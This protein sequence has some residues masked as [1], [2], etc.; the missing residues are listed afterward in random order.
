MAIT[1]TTAYLSELKKNVNTPNVIVEVSLDSGTLK[2]GFH[3]GGFSDVR[4]LLKSIG[5]LQNRLDTE[6][7]YSTRGQL[8]LVIT[9]RDNFKNFIK[10]NYLKNRRIVRKDGFLG[11]AYSD[12]ASTFSGKI[13]DWNRKGDELTLI[14]GDDL[15]VDAKKKLPVENTAKTQYLDYR[16][17]NPVDIMLDL[18]QTRL[19]ISSSLI[20]T[21]QFNSEKETWLAGWKFDRVLTKPEETN[22]YLNELQIETNS[23]IVHDGEKIT[24][25]HFG[26]AVP[27]QTVEEWN[28]A[29]H[30]LSGSFSQKSGYNDNFFNRIVLYYDYDESGNDKEE[31][32]ESAYIAADAG[33][34]DA[35]Q[36]NEVKT[37][38]IKSKWLRSLT[39]TQPTNITGVVIYHVSRINGVGSGTLTYKKNDKTLTWMRPGGWQEG[40][41]VTLSKDGTYQI[42]DTDK[43]KWVRVIVTTVSLPT[44]N[45]TDT[46]AISSLAGE[47]FAAYVTGKILNRYRDPVAHVSFSID[48]NS[49]AFNSAFV[50]PTDL[51]DLTT[52]EA[53]GKG[54]GAWSK[55]RLMLTS[56]RPD[57]QS[58]KVSLEAVQTKV[59]RRYGFIAPP[60]FPDYPGASVGQREY[61]F[62]GRASDNK[63]NNGTE[64]GFVI[65]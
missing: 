24:F 54:K 32:F 64:E 63:V 25:K 38:T 58:S 46:I 40:E 42:Y 56:V 12:Y 59:Y 47:N 23:F 57:F 4:P 13:L 27:G 36:W 21:A 8:T 49:V 43:T 14:V 50:K 29:G 61:A 10:D 1:L 51:K 22:K 15:A 55:E 11:T 37:K 3:T 52:D 33:S 65:W 44:A 41:E 26:P 53:C 62:I 48:T 31:N 19:G 34:Q 7:G 60:G 9:G 20:D 30:I 28:D 45:K 17:A 2:W 16:N 18:M 5:S 6:S 39:Y 35:T